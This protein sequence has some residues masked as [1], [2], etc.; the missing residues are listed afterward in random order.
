MVLMNTRKRFAPAGCAAELR[1]ARRRRL[2]ARCLTGCLTGV[3]MLA[4]AGCAKP[5]VELAGGGGASWSQWQG[6]WVLVNYWAEWCAPC[7]KE[8]PE[9]NDIHE[10]GDELGVV[11][12]GVNFD[13]VR[14]EPL[15]A[16]MEELDIQFPV[17]LQDPRERWNLPVP[18]VL[19]STLVIDPEGN[20]HEVLVGP[21]TVE[22][23]TRAMALSSEV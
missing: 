7:R 22:S 12:L 21:Q 1:S 10:E 2:R 5:E 17:L 11:V 14:G 3:L 4:L 8:I 9:L 18:S 13:G 23:L 6:K 16:L 19:P 20:L 15:S